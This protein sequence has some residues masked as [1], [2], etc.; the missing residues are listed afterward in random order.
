MEQR[1]EGPTSAAAPPA[2]GLSRHL[3]DL[4][5]PVLLAT[6]LLCWSQERCFVDFSHRGTRLRS[7]KTSDH[8]APPVD[9]GRV[10]ETSHC[11]ASAKLP[12]LPLLQREGA[13]LA[14][15]SAGI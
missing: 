7:V 13:A 2:P 9:L 1:D 8:P 6:R 3:P 14:L 12:Q 11:C 4:P 15:P 10:P 5:S